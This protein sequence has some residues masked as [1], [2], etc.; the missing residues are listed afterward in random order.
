[1]PTG[2]TPVAGAPSRVAAALRHLGP[3][4]FDGRCKS[5]RLISDLAG[6][7]LER[8]RILCDRIA[9]D[10]ENVY[11][12]RIGLPLSIPASG[13]LLL[14]SD[15]H[16]YREYVAAEEDL[17]AGY[18]GFAMPWAGIV[19]LPAGDVAEDEIARTLAHELAHLA[20]RR[21]F[22]RELPPWLDEGLADAMGESATSRG[23]LPL[24]DEA[25]M[26]ALRRRLADGY[27]SGRVAALTTLVALD[28][29]TFDRAPAAYDYEQAALFVRFLLL[30][31]ALAP[32]FRLW[33]SDLAAC[34]EDLAGELPSALASSWP[35]LE[36][37]FRLAYSFD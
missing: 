2:L 5:Y 3:L 14:F 1:M 30:D 12:E 6:V 7:R 4:R 16:R 37:R 20:R 19:A 22:G 9:G 28:R 26:A 32:A 21:A 11:P 15:R 33:L 13:T 36:H 29:D 17:A 18:A 35:D 24:S 23:F 25:P 31:P 8:L 10:L 34:G 27:R